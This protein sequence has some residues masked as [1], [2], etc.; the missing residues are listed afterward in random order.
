MLNAAVSTATEVETPTETTEQVLL[1][2]LFNPA[3]DAMEEYYGE[4]RQY[5]RDSILS[6]QKV[7]DTP[8]YEVIMQAETFHGAHNPPYGL[9]TMT[10]YVSYGNVE[11]KNYKHQDKPG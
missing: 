2:L 5:W 1:R 8:Y 10:F 9:E 7:P 4:S 6:V 11:L 3:H